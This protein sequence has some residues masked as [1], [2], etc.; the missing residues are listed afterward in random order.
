MAQFSL[1]KYVHKGGLKPHS[2]HFI[3]C[4]LEFDPRIVLFTFPTC[5]RTYSVKRGDVTR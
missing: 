2:F 3:S 4:S 5:V 1:Y